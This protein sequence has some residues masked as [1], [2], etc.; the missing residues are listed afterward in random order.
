MLSAE[1]TVKNA[2]L[3]FRG[4]T[5]TVILHI[6]LNI[7]VLL[8]DANTDHPVFRRIVV[9]IV[10]QVADDLAHTLGEQCLQLYA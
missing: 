5:H 7:A 10:H 9:G 8:M 3:I 1:E 4:N 6:H 2:R